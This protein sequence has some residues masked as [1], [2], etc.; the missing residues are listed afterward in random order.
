[1]AKLLGILRHAKSEWDESV[2]RDFDR[3][4]N[5]RGRRGAVLIGQHVRDHAIAWDTLIASPAVRLKETLELAELGIE[6]RYEDR[7]YLA[8]AQ[9]IIELIEGLSGP[10]EPDAILV[11]GHN[12][13]LQETLLELVAPAREND[14]FREATVK[15]P[16]SAFAVLE[17]EIE[18]WA[19]L[20]PRCATMIHFARPRDLDPALGPQ[21]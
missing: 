12:P 7:L 19:G 3:G 13:G 8:S 15:F 1:M 14:L 5:D 9:T 4:L 21:N 20:K 18:S 16:T 2:K 11:A 6:P 17:C 10:D